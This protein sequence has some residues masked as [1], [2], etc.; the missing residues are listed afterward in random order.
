MKI[1]T[2]W[3]INFILLFS[4]ICLTAL[5]SCSTENDN[6]NS[7]QSV[8]DSNLN[9]QNKKG[10]YPENISNIYDLA[11]Q[12]HNEISENYL[13]SGLVSTT[14]EETILH[15]EAL[16]NV[17]AEFQ[18][19][20]PTGYTSPTSLHV[21]SILYNT[22]DVIP[23]SI[24]SPDSRLSLTTFLNTLMLYKEQQIEYD[25][26]YKFIIDYE[27]SII[28]DDSLSVIDQRIILSTTSISRYGFYF[29]KKHRRKPRDRDWEIM[30]ANVLAGTDGS[31]ESMAKAIIMSATCGIISNK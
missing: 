23:N 8:G 25:T 27:T 5:V 24:M 16:A 3:K 1:L 12:L 9:I 21:D 13:A 29:A 4:L 20:T 10:L 18:S 2:Q 26:I 7:L 15:V 17:N 14:T 30:W 6:V 11:G 22:H 28:S 19:L 31:E